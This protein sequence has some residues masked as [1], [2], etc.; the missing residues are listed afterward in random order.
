MSGYSENNGYFCGRQYLCNDPTNKSDFTHLTPFFM[1]N[2]CLISLLLMAGMSLSASA[3]RLPMKLWYDRPATF[4]EESLP[5]G[6][7]KLGALV[8]GGVEKEVVQLNDITLWTGQPVDRNEDKE[9]H[10]WIPKIREALFSENYQLADSLQLHVQGHNSAYYQP[11]TTLHIDHLD[12]STQ[13][14]HY[15]RELDLDSALAKVYYQKGGVVYRREYLASHPDRA[16]VIRLTANKAHALNCRLWLSSLLP[17]Q[18]AA[19]GHRIVVKGHAMGEA[20]NTIQ[21]CNILQVKAHGGTVTA[22]G[23]G[24]ILKEVSEATIYLV[25]ETSYHGFDQHPVRQGAPYVEEAE[26]DLRRIGNR[27][28]DELK[29]RHTADYRRLFGRMSWQLA[30]AKFDTRRTTEQQ[31]RDYTDQGGGNPYLEMLYFQFGRYLLISSSRT[32]GLPATLQGVWNPHLKA[33]WRSNYTVNI[34][35]EENYWPAEVANL[36]EM[37]MPL[38]GLVKALSENGKYTARNYYGIEEGWCSSHNSDAWAMTNPVGEKR[39]SPEW[40][41]WNLGGAWLL[42]NVWEH[43][44]FTQDRR[45]LSDEAYP[46]MKGACDFMLKWLVENPHCPGELITAPSTSPENEYIT[47]QGYHGTTLYGGSADLAILRELFANTITATE[48]LH[49]GSTEYSRKLRE[50]LARLRPY[51]IG[52]DGDLNEWYNDW[53]DF[54]PQHRHQSHLIGLYPGHHISPTKTP[55]LAQAARK[56]LEQKGDETT[57]WSTGWRINLWAR[58]DEGEKAYRLFQKLLTYVSPDHYTG[59]DKRHSG[60]TY[61]NLFDAHPPFQIDGNFGGTAGICEM[62]VQSAEGIRLLP[63]LP[64]AWKTGSVKGICARGGFVIDM[65]WK[66]GQVTRARIKSRVGGTVTVAYNG[67]RKNLT[68]KAGQERTLK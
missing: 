1:Q 52:K 32:P 36:S 21:F 62:L 64:S 6:N 30:G 57:G 3:Q 25:N 39:E 45:Y 4:F 37:A 46:L 7:G 44:A 29:Q 18:S 53:R 51:I 40:A 28:F 47:P 12:G 31:L 60:G 68:F 16:I 33:P 38:V 23:D 49:N 5:L 20:E 65:D 55:E 54:D 61:P 22:D 11:L 66:D 14:D 42:S 35:L 63:A 24:L 13:A 34:N 67:K 10:R 9:A 27:S 8:Y 17:H 26:A 43:Y 50:T 2:R 41:N 48:L 19:M 59:A 15:R 56:T 58:L